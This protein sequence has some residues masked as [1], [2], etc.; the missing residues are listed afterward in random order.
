MPSRYAGLP[1]IIVVAPDGSQRVL[2]APRVAPAPDRTVGSY[3]VHAGDRLDLLARAV[4][5]DGT[6]WW[7]I[8][9]A[10][11][12]DDAADLETPGRRIQ[13]PEG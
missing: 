13:L 10:N 1:A 8:A 9:D 5:G 2:S 4:L 3:T 7:R 11:P 12:V 6:A